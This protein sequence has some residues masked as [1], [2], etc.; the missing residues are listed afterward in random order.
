MSAGRGEKRAKSKVA[1][2]PRDVVG[3]ELARRRAAA[4]LE[5]LA[6]VLT[7]TEG[8]AALELQLA[9]YYVL[10]ARALGAMVAAL[11]PRARGRRRTFAR[12]LEVARLE[13]DRLEG[14]VRRLS[15]L[16]RAAER[17]VGL[18]Q[19]ARGSAKR[20][21]SEPRGRR[22]VRALRAKRGPPESKTPKTP[23]EPTS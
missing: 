5:V 7:P 6:G 2:S 15:G 1:S 3:S 14:E 17:V 19:D 11:E 10:E 4:I 12:E 21:R 13:R 18:P 16:L 8:A 22:V 20:R 23:P 9:R